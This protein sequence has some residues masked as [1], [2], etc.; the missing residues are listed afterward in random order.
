M[1]RPSRRGHTGRVGA[2]GYAFVGRWI[3]G[4]LGWA[5]VRHIGSDDVEVP[6]DCF[7]DNADEEDR[8][9]LCRVTVE[10]VFDTKGRE[11]TRRA[12]KFRMPR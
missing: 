3:D 11:I 2:T 4:T 12:L 9:V 5:G 10:Q 1:K 7:E 8:A 6:S